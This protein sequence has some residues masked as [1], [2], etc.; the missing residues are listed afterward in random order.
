MSQ[1]PFAKYD[2]EWKSLDS[3]PDNKTVQLKVCGHIFLAMRRPDGFWRD[4]W[5]GPLKM[6]PVVR[7]DQW[8]WRDLPCG[9]VPE[10][11]QW[12]QLEDSGT[13]QQTDREA[14]P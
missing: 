8:Q 11:K 10:T 13:S 2:A 6:A 9:I 3:L 5:R 7:P 4:Y 12:R 1:L 14:E